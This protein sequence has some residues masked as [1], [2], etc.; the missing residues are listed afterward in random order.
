MIGTSLWSSA[1][2]CECESARRQLTLLW[3]DEEPAACLLQGRRERA[4]DEVLH[5]RCNQAVD[6]RFTEIEL[7]GPIATEEQLV[8]SQ[9]GC[10]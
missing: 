4:V 9:S 5:A 8:W 1:C 7:A 3:L 10:R 2:E 6:D